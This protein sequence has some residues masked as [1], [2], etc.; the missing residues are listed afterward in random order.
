MLASFRAI[1]DLAKPLAT[2]ILLDLHLSS[3][4]TGQII[5]IDHFGNA[6][7]NIPASAVP[8]NVQVRVARLTLP[9]RRTYSDV[10]PG[11]ALALIGSNEL[12]EIAIRDGSA[13]SQ[14]SLKVGDAV[15]L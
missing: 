15:T 7:T 12:L 5:H 9:L 8:P 3:G 14:L 1:L 6:T 2:P 11:Q 13:A 10:A 4:P